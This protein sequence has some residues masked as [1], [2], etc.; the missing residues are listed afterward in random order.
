MVVLVGTNDSPE[1]RAALRAGAEEARRRGAELVWL[2]VG[3]R[4]VDPS[5]VPDGAR[6]VVRPEH[7]DPEAALIDAASYEH[8]EVLVIG[9]RR[10]S[11]VGK[12]LMGSLVQRVI[13]DS[14]VP[15]LAVKADP[16]P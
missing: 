6:E 16:S 9:V 11:P 13:L 1:G 10:R 4:A 3:P 7:Q 12:F 2:N 15:V 8:A 14:T 5:W